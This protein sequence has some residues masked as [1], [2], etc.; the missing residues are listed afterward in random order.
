MLWDNLIQRLHFTLGP[1]VQEV[2]HRT[3]FLQDKVNIDGEV[4]A[5]FGVSQP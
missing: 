3:D 5:R 1:G 4:R 2:E